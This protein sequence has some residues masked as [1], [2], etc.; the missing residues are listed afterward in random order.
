MRRPS[1]SRRE[2]NWNSPPS[3]RSPSKAQSDPKSRERRLPASWRAREERRQSPTPPQ[4]PE[5]RPR[6]MREKRTGASSFVPSRHR[7]RHIHGASPILR[8]FCEGWEIRAREIGLTGQKLVLPV[9]R[10]R[11]TA[12][13]KSHAAR[14]KRDP[15]P[16]RHADLLVQGKPRNERQQNV[17]ERGRGQN[18]GQ[19]GPRK[20]VHVAG[21]ECEQQHNSNRNPRIKHGKN[22]AGKVM[23]GNIAGLLHAVRKHGVSGRSKDGYSGQDEIFAEGHVKD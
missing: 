15:N 17:S 1:R 21:E 13:H 9:S 18:V 14:N 8:A 7:L 19:V 20:R 22:Y 6:Y 16:S 12:R 23:Q 5:F 2:R 11:R 3:E 10:K 4:S